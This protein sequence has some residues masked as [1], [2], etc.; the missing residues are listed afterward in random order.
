MAGSR[1]W[2]ILLMVR[3]LGIGGC[4][5]DLTKLAKKLDRTR[6]APHVGC[7]HSEGLR[8]AELQAAGIPIVR[9]PVTSLKSW[10]AIEGGRQ[11]GRY[12][13]DN[14]IVIVH[15]FDV[16]TVLFAIPAARFHRTPVIIANQLAYRDLFPPLYQRM[17]RVT[18]RLADCVVSNSQAVQQYL[19]DQEHV[20]AGRTYLCY[21]GVETEVFHP[22][23][24]PRPPALAGASL[25]IGAICAL[26]PEKRLDLLLQAF[27]RIRHLR[28]GIKLLIV[29]SGPVLPSLTNLCTALGLDD[30]CIFEPSKTDV[31][32]WMRAI[33]VFVMSSESESFPNAL[34]EAMASGCAPVGSRVGG[35]PELISPNQTGLL[36][37]S[38]DIEGLAAALSLLI[39]DEP[40]RLRLS[41]AAVRSARENFS[42]EINASCNQQLYDRL[43]KQKG[44]V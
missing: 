3:E 36:F 10:S 37:E 4:E 13:K 40:L 17:L 27:S 38:G 6:F 1:P 8:T 32:P 31:A 29:G 33:D 28:D 12:L 25:V 14:G 18:D 30:A 20:P 15:A 19:I 34:L 2:P 39:A 22:S 9:F 24:E 35:I 44:F 26:R 43:L 16:P 21:N 23:P 41:Q 5:R 42:M 11:M 7:F